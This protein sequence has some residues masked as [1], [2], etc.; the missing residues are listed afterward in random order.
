[1]LLGGAGMSG[2]RH[3]TL[4]MVLVLIGTAVSLLASAPPSAAHT[5]VE[6]GPYEFEVG[7]LEEPPIVGLL[8][9]VFLGLSWVVNG[10]PVVGVQDRLTVTLLT[11]PASMVGSLEPLFSEPGGYTFP[12]IPTREGSYS[13]RVEGSLNGTTVNF[14]QEIEAVAGRSD[15]E[16]PVDDPT[17][18]ELDQAIGAVEAENTALRA[19]L[20][21][22]LA[23]AVAGAVIGTVGLAVGVF[24]WRRTDQ[25]P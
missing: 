18:P 4:I 10:T 23:L 21:A 14:T 15:F 2:R 11:G 25:K 22:A 24:A 12:V 16:F 20:G 19:Q 8:N 9:G 3:A 13:V 6:V 5:H 1:L 17:P 7:W